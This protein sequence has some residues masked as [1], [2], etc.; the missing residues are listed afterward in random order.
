M[1]ATTATLILFAFT[2]SVTAEDLCPKYGSCVPA[3]Q[4]EC[5]HITRSSFVQRVC[6]SEAKAY[7]IVRLKKTYYHYCAVD[8]GTV[9][10]F[11]SADSMGR[12]YNQRIKVDAND[13]KFDCRTHQVPTF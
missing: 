8:P 10:D 11:L 12:F 4:F 5:H 3:D 1:R 9:N 7:M 13:G 6:Y 2:S